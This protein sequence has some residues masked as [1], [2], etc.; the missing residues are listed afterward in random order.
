MGRSLWPHRSV[1]RRRTVVGLAAL[2]MLIGY[3]GISGGSLNRGDIPEATVR[4]LEAINRTDGVPDVVQNVV[5]GAIAARDEATAAYQVAGADADPLSKP[6]YLVVWAGKMTP[7]DVSGGQLAHVANGTVKPEDMA[8][9]A[10]I[11]MKPGL[12]AMIVVDARR[13]N[14]DGT[15]SESYGKI[16]NFVQVPPPFGVEG[17]PHHLQYQWEDGQPVVAGGLFNDVTTV[18]DVSRIPEI[19]LANIIRPEETPL[20]T[21]P[22]AYDF[23]PDGRAIGTYMG[24]PDLNFAGSPG[25]VVV[26]RP[27]PDKG[28]VFESETPAGNPGAVSSSN[29]GGV[30]EPCSP[31]EAKPLGTCA[32]P[33]GI[34]IRADLRRMVTADYAE[35]RE[36]VTDP[37]KGYKPATFRPTVRIWDV[38]SPGAPRLESV[39]RMPKGPQA[40]LLGHGNI[41]IMETAKT[42]APA[43]GFFAGASCGGG[44]FFTPDITMLTGDSS[45]AWKQVFVDDMAIHSGEAGSCAGGSWHQV[46]PDNRFLFRTVMG[47]NPGST[48]SFD[49]G[50]GRYIY[51]L[52][53]APLITS[54]ADGHVDCNVDT[55]AEIQRG[56]GDEPDCPRLVSALPVE[57][58]TT[59]GPHWAA[60]DNHSLTAT[61]APTRLVFSN[62][63]VART[64]VDGNHRMYMVDVDPATGALAYDQSFRDEETGTLGVEFNRRNWPNNPDVGFYKPHAM[65][66]VCPPGVCPE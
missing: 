2:A 22:D 19:R 8:E 1:W 35:P 40:S 42:H 23:L 25:S 11:G 54:A 60:I 37:V 4:S 26:L 66:W 41:A 13:H 17:E 9:L 29:A 14:P 3:A 48:Q 12:D 43:K 18:W 45:V 64:G 39:A 36:L 20:G 62:S 16:V 65:V 63:F 7:G 30:P 56:Q 44:I 15:L 53:I 10:G 47:R 51:S 34:Q 46:S 28:L 21:V 27:H 50:T 24:G 32:N 33:H 58:S 52:D 59:G 31:V 49:A 38:T 61:S 5:P 55:I 6:E 57:D